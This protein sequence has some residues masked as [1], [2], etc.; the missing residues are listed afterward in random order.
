VGP[1]KR[2]QA[3]RGEHLDVALRQGPPPDARMV[4][5]PEAE[6]IKAERLSESRTRAAE[7][8]KCSSQAAA[9]AGAAQGGGRTLDNDIIGHIIYNI[10]YNIISMNFDVI[11]MIS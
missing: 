8:R 1:G 10:M 5:I 6:R 2:Q 4:S 9:A 11:V 3:L 7:T